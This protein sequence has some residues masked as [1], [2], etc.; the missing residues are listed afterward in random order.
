MKKQSIIKIV[1][2]LQLYYGRCLLFS[3]TLILVYILHSEKESYLIIK[4]TYA[5]EWQHFFII[6]Q[7]L[8][9]FPWKM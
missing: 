3:I 6:F 7:Y 8:Y 1:K 9:F 2:G 4:L 5:N